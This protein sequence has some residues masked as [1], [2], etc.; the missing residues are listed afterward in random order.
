MGRF[1]RES[2]SATRPV[3]HWRMLDLLAKSWIVMIPHA[4]PYQMAEKAA[5]AEISRWANRPNLMEK[6]TR[7]EGEKDE[8]EKPKKKGKSTKDA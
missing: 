1:L 5:Q 4:D 2:L 3:R 8:Q 7:D 6:K